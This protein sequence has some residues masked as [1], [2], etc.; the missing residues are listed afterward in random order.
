[1]NITI[2]MAAAGVYSFRSTFNIAKTIAPKN[3]TIFRL[4]GLLLSATDFCLSSASSVQE[5]GYHFQCLCF[6]RFQIIVYNDRIEFRCKAKLVFGLRHTALDNFGSIRAAAIKRLRSSSTEGGWM[7][8]D[9]A[10]S[11]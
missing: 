2:S 10:R 11:P 1:M 3:R 8:T 6:S 7:K 5:L 9:K 4:R